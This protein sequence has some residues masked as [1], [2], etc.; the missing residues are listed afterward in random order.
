GGQAMTFNRRHLFAALLAALAPP[1]SGRP[2]AAPAAPP[3]CPP[4][5]HRAATS[6][7][8]LPG[9][10][11]IPYLSYCPACGQPLHGC[12]LSPAPG[13]VIYST[14]VGGCP[15]P[16]E[17]LPAGTPSASSPPP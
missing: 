12:L 1:W 4:P 15:C 10:D 7:A 5:A 9:S 17:L 2:A 3:P 16:P 11:E 13:Q 14:Y 8:V 6:P